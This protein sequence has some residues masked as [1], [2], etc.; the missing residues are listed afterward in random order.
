MEDLRDKVQ[1]ERTFLKKIELAIPGFRGY[2]KRED[3][4]IADSMLRDYIANIM[5]D[6]EK[7]VKEV[8]S[9][10]QE[11]MALDDMD[12]IG[13]IINRVATMEERIRHA[14]QG[15]MGLVGDYRVGEE[16]LNNLYEFD[17]KLIEESQ[18]L[19]E[20]AKEMA[21]SDLN[22]VR[23]MMRSFPS[24]LNEIEELFEKRRN[25]MLEVFK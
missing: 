8:R 16:Q 20:F 19:L 10:L 9:Y 23:E 18:N 4:R 25:E 22:T 3:L 5:K 1:R 11:N 24:K 12:T 6:V 13:K 21:H 17:L 7:Y 15:Y 2:R 14:E